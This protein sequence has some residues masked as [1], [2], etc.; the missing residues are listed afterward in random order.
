MCAV[1]SETG[2]DEIWLQWP[3]VTLA[4]A[5]LVAHEMG[6]IIRKVDDLSL[7]FIEKDLE[8]VN[9]AGY[10][11]SVLEDRIIDEMLKVKYN[12]NLINHYIEAMTSI[13]KSMRSLLFKKG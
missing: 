2:T 12:F 10:I 13:R 11:R 8:Y 7:Q 4:D 6:H 9:V 3:P 1:N 5:Y